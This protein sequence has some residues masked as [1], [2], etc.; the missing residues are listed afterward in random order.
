[1]EIQSLEFQSI[2][3]HREHREF[4]NCYTTDSVKKD[5]QFLN[6]VYDNKTGFN[7][8]SVTP[9]L[10]KQLK[11]L[12]KRIYYFILSMDKNI[13]PQ[14]YIKRKYEFIK[15][16][17]PDNNPHLFFLAWNGLIIND[18][19][20]RLMLQHF[21]LRKFN[22]EI[23][24]RNIP[25]LSS[26]MTRYRTKLVLADDMAIDDAKKI[27]KKGRSLND[28]SGL[29]MQ[30]GIVWLPNGKAFPLYPQAYVPLN[31]THVILVRHG[32][33]HHDSGGDDPVFVGSGYWDKWKNNRRV[34]GSIGNY[35]HEDGINTAR[36]LGKDFKIFVS[37]LSKEG[38]AMWPFSKEKPIRVFGSESENTEQTSRYFLQEASYTNISFKSLYG[39]NS[40][41]YGALTHKYK[42]DIYKKTIDIYQK[43]WKG[44]EKELKTKMKKHFKNRFFHYPEGET[45]LEADWRI[46]FSFVEM[47]K[48]NIGNRIMLADHSGAIRVF[49]A[50]IRTLDFA[51]Y[52]SLKEKHESII[53]LNYQPGMNIRYDYIQKKEYMLRKR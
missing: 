44:T 45:L 40:Q 11:Y 32:R 36:E 19:F 29:T 9:K 31:Q 51:D 2:I 17:F 26:N 8:K 14:F 53:A 47:L 50:I 23:C 4:H 41:K 10:I 28:G 46:A 22:D 43:G 12:G 24:P 20:K 52:S 25:E 18:S 35:L 49:A 5:I 15:N 16:Y 37:E 33:S 30:E 13:T 38:Y 7:S 34:S 27:R 6:M 39:I 3:S 1:M 48:N 21:S 42:S